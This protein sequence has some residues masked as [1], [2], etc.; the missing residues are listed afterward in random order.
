MAKSFALR[1][2][3]SG[4]RNEEDIIAKIA[5]GEFSKESM[6]RVM[7]KE[8]KRTA[9]DEKFKLGSSRKTRDKKQ[10]NRGLLSDNVSVESRKIG[11]D[12]KNSSSKPLARRIDLQPLRKMGKGKLTASGKFRKSNGGYFKKKL[13]EQQISEFSS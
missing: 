13:R 7:D 3:P 2:S 9:R 10:R 6:S 12:D 8:S 4:L 5:N 11:E 1:E